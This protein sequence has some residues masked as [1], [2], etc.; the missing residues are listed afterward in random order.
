MQTINQRTEEAYLDGDV[1][2]GEPYIDI[3]RNGIYDR[4]IDIFNR[5][6]DPLLNHDKNYNG[7][8][9]GPCY[10]QNCVFE[11]G[12]TFEDRNGN[13][14]YD[15]PNF[16]YDYGE[17]FTDANGNGR[18]DFGSQSSFLDPGSFA[19][20][21][22]WQHRVVENLRFEIKLFRQMG[23]HQLKAGFSATKSNY[24]YQDIKRPYLPYTGRPD[25]G[26]YPERGQ[27]R[28]MWQY[29]P[30]S[31]TGYF[32]DKI[33]Y[34][35][36]IAMLGLRWDFYI[37]DVE[38]LIPIAIA[39]DLGSGLIYGDRHK[40]SPRIGFSYPISDKAKVHFNYGH[41]F[42]MAS[43]QFMYA[44]N[45]QSVDVNS[46]VGNYNLDY[47]K[48]IQYSFGVKYKLNENYALD[49]SSYFKD[50]FDKVNQG[51]RRV[52]NISR[53]QYLN[54]DYG[55]AK[56]F[57]FE[58]DKVGGGYVSGRVSYVY[59]FA[60]GKSSQTNENYLDDFYRSREP[61]S[62]SPLNNDV[63]HTFKSSVQIYIPKT[64]KP[65]VFGLPI[66]ND[67]SLTIQTVIMS[68]FP[69]TPSSKLP[70]ISSGTSESIG[71][72][73][74]RYPSTSV[75][76]V[77]FNKNFELAGLDMTYILWIENLFDQR[78]VDNIYSET[79]RPDTQ[80]NI[81]GVIFGGTEYDRNPG[82]WDYGRQIR[83]GFG[84]SL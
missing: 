22:R 42:Q 8:Y 31:G 30:W 12:L 82:N 41:F 75:F 79:G 28:D 15:A 53:V 83:M 9:D 25:D 27:F 37:Q 62:E 56:G 11:P 51:E 35:S 63:R 73:S 78:N 80:Q 59:A 18:H 44:R 54:K 21:A 38:R 84:L 32:R 43:F 16:Q 34:G 6:T 5:S 52:G 70:G 74:M 36:M 55:R 72:N 3:N 2:I 58:L 20:D 71:T 23:N 40:I 10:G 66:P 39:D 77:R 67:W 33:E 49:I 1:I 69:F 65:R 19:T 50:E 68:G 64:V 48:T 4:G 26:P 76:D 29:K 81:N 47:Q 7:K 14:V 46:V 57:E 17:P 60:T 45:T 13:G 24:E 61:L